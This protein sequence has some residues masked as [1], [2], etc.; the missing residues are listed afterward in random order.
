MERKLGETAYVRKGHRRSQPQQTTRCRGPGCGPALT[1]LMLLV[2]M[3]DLLQ[4]ETRVRCQHMDVNVDELAVKYSLRQN[5]AMLTHLTQYPLLCSLPRSSHMR[6]R[7]WCLAL[8]VQHQPSSGP[9]RGAWQRGS[10]RKMRW[11]SW[12]RPP[13]APLT[14]ALGCQQTAAPS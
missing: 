14:L 12:R 9:V 6:R 11:M 1:P 2:H 10:T 3:H 4:Y 7:S 8:Y 13:L 5:I